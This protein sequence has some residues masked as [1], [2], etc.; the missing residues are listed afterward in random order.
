MAEN[1]GEQ[2]K[3]K[4]MAC[5]Y[6]QARFI[7]KLWLNIHIFGILPLTLT[8]RCPF[9]YL[10]RHNKVHSLR[11]KK[12]ILL[13]QFTLFLLLDNHVGVACVVTT[14]V[15]ADTTSAGVPPKDRKGTETRHMMWR[16]VKLRLLT[17]AYYSDLVLTSN[18]RFL[19]RLE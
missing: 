14:Q 6:H 9:S 5:H 1:T 16:L 18:M 10:Q 7:T 8:F 19:Y 13:G 15:P 4:L 3:E 2:S 17:V 12:T 11:N